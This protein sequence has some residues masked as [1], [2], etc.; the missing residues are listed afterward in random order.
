VSPIDNVR[1]PY[2][3]PSHRDDIQGI[4]QHVQKRYISP[5]VSIEGGTSYGFPHG[6]GEVPAV[7]SVLEATDSQGTGAA[8]ASSMTATKTVTLVTVANTA[9]AGTVRFFRVRAF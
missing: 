1:E 4:K 8:D 3:E 6:L 5:W 9:A 2:N 7:V